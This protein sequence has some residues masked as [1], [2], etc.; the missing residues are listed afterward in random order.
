MQ[1]GLFFML[2]G[3]RLVHRLRELSLIASAPLG[4]PIEAAGVKR[5]YW[6]SIS[7]GVTYTSLSQ[8]EY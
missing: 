3:N 6:E 4:R 7:V 2:E 1:K 5:P 8:L